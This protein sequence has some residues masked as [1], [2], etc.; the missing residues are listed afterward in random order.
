MRRQIE[1]NVKSHRR[2]AVRM[3]A[4]ARTELPLIEPWPP[5]TEESRKDLP[6]SLWRGRRLATTSVL[7]YLCFRLLA[8]AVEKH[9]MC[10][11]CSTGSR[12]P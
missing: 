10:A 9:H 3:E 7:D 1:D 4:E 11:V 5:G 8:S 2:T 6:V 12:Q